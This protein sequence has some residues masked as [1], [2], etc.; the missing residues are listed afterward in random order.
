MKFILRTTKSSRALW[1]KLTI[2]SFA[3]VLVTVPA[4]LAVLN[5]LGIK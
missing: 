3:V 5:H 2:L 4:T 1:Q